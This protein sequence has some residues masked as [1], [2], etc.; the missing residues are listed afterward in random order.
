[1]GNPLVSI[2]MAVW[3]GELFIADTLS[4]LLAQ[5][6]QNLEIILLD[7]L[8]TDRTSLI[9][10]EFARKDKRVRYIL[11]KERTDVIEGQKRVFRQARGEFFMIACDDD[12]YAPSYVSSLLALM[13]SDPG[14]GLAYSSYEYISEVGVRSSANFN[15][16]YL[17]T[18]RSTKT[19]NFMHYLRHRN[20]IPIMF[21]LVRANVHADA[22]PYYDR[23]DKGGW[24]HDNL[25][26]LRL[27]T[28]ARVDSTGAPLFFYRQRD[29]DVLYSARGQLV[30]NV[31][32]WKTYA[33]QVRH[34]IRVTRTIHRIIGEA[35]FG[36]ARKI[37]LTLYADLM[38]LVR[39][40]TLT[41][42]L[43][44][45]SFRGLRRRIST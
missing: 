32:K 7:N 21:G 12:V 37:L 2:G 40:K 3:N 34:Q 33:D 27:L 44:P 30:S 24:D 43:V 15:R 4:S 9:C 16:K 35:N 29:R 17:L 45:W 41:R 39:L 6:Y 14:T 25:Y 23:V 42:R 18:K 1:M 22:L 10:E 20:P 13:Q 19:R 5:D 28:L 38:L 11:D 36:Y 31:S 26:I 8:S